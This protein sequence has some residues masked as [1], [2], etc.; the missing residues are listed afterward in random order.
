MLCYVT[1]YSD[2]FL[3]PVDKNM[4]SSAC[5]VKAVCSSEILITTHQTILCH[6]PE[7]YNASI[8]G[9]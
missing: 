5:K 4:L 1:V 7:G 3:S 2:G 6:N 9:I 8:Q